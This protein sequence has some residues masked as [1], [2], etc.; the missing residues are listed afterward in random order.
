[1]SFRTASAILRGKWL[2][3]PSYAQAQLPLVLQMLN[4][5][6]AG[7][8]NDQAAIYKD[9]LEHKPKVF[10]PT[11]VNVAGVPN[12]LFSVS[13]YTSTDRLPYNSIAIV[14]VLGPILK[15]GDFCTY[16]TVEFN[17][18]LIRLAN[19]DRVKGILLNMDTPGGQAAGTATVAQTT[20]EVSKI[21]PVLGICQDGIVASAG[22]WWASACQ[23]FYVTQSTDQVGSIGAYQTIADFAGYFE[24]NGV[25]LHEIYAPQSVDKNKDYRDA[26]KGDYTLIEEDLKFLVQDFIK[27]VQINR[28]QRLKTATENPF[29]GKMYNAA[30]AVKIGLIDGIKPM[31]A[32]VKRMEQLIAL[33]A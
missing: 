27:T 31:A 12:E 17:D 33:R 5:R 30:D 18:L 32:V 2:I 13:P 28:G 22:M 29:T 14:D 10:Q 1:M 4:E 6:N 3:E 26:L 23:E 11:R 19:S 16:G 8:G 25:K 20:K 15:Y 7:S 9:R 24:Q 21:K